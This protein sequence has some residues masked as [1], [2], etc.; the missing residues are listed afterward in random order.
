MAAA[1]ALLHAVALCCLLVSG[2][3]AV[4]PE[5]LKSTDAAGR[6]GPFHQHG[7]PAVVTVVT[8]TTGKAELARA[9]ESVRRQ[10]RSPSP[11]LPHTKLGTAA[12]AWADEVWGGWVLCLRD[13]AAP[14]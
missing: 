14:L 9:I 5:A 13:T 6:A 3:C 7:E 4:A 8:A 10:V 1:L 12:R 2:C 11:T